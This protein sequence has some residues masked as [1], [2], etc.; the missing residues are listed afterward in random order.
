MRF[1]GDPAIYRYWEATHCAEFGYRMAQ[2]ALE[3]DLRKETE[4]LARYDG[5]LKGGERA[6]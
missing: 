2:Q 6:I 5:V 4:F 3:F 1:Q